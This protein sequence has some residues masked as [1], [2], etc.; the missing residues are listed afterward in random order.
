MPVATPSTGGLNFQQLSYLTGGASR[1]SFG[2][3]GVNPGATA[4][5]NVLASFALP[6]SLFDGSSNRGVRITAFG[7][8]AANTNVKTVKLIVNPATAVVGSTIGAGGTTLVT[9]GALSVAT[10]LQFFLEAMVVDVTGVNNQLGIGLLSW[11]AV[12]GA[13]TFAALV[14]PAAITADETQPFLIAVTGNAATAVTDISLL[15]F[16]VG[17]LNP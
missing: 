2:P 12:A 5:D 11:W 9:T 4:A 14:A 8:F 3:T 7:T 6:G 1:T 17:N 15:Y 16:N 10:N 13:P